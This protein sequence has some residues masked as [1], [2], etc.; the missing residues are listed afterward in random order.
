MLSFARPVVAPWQLA[1]VAA[2]FIVHADNSRLFADLFSLV[3]LTSPHGAV[4]VFSVISLMTCV[5]FSMMLAIGVGRLLKIVVAVFL[6]VSATVGYFVN[7]LGVVFDQQMLA[8]VRDTLVERN[9]SEAREL[10]SAALLWNVFLLGI[11]P[12]VLLIP[13]RLRS[14]GPLQELRDRVVSLSIVAAV[15]AVSL[16]GD[17]RMISYFAVEHRDL[18][19]EVTPVHALVSLIRLTGDTVRREPPFRVLHAAATRDDDGERRIVGIM[20]VGE[21]A[22]ADHFSLNGY[23]R[24][25]NPLMQ[26]QEGLEFLDIDACGTSTAYS[27]PCMFFLRGRE[28]YSPAI[29]RSESN[30]LDVLQ[31]TGVEAVWIENNSTCKHVCDRIDT[32]NLRMQ[33][34]GSVMHE[35]E[36][37][38]ELVKAA[39][40]YM[41]PEGPDRL[42][43]L[44]TMGSHGPAY[45]RRY[46]DE[47]ARF[48]PSCHAVSPKDC[49]IEE[50]EN[51][52][53]NSI[54]YTDFVIGR[55]IDRL[56]AH[57]NEFDSFLLYASDHGESLGENGVYLHGMPYMVA[58]ESQTD[59]PLVLWLSPEMRPRVGA[60]GWHGSEQ[61]SARPSH[62]NIP[63]TLLGLYGVH[64]AMYNTEEDLLSQAR[65]RA[66]VTAAVGG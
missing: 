22:R 18:R 27:V 44:H 29:A 65:G 52:Y 15:A 8:N 12:S 45:S 2:V 6:I 39:E 4:L 36:F 14:N 26:Q 48:A 66:T 5:L 46:P 21:T 13:I 40:E 57:R 17:Y 63:H 47:F 34:N 7:E 28:N 1:L 41:T 32:V 37:D 49:S 33:P 58:P 53:D 24:L 51:A 9:V 25:T 35:G 59:V 60:V 23:A 31:A 19:F 64:S 20:V 43:V 30:V 10:A 54:L 55:L 3:D 38:I 42:I 50:V 56:E 11:L 62:D 16:F 61:Q